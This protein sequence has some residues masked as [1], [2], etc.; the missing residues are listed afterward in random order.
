MKQSPAMGRAMQHLHHHRYSALVLRRRHAASVHT[1]IYP[2][3]SGISCSSFGTA[4]LAFSSPVAFAI[5]VFV[6]LLLPRE[7]VWSNFASL[8]A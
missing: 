4:A 3:A 8:A 6:S 1:G 5:T 2:F 7:E